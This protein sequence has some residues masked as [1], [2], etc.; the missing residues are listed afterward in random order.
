MS[1]IFVGID[2]GESG[3]M[4]AM[5]ADSSILFARPWKGEVEAIES[6][7]FAA[8]HGGVEA[9]IERVGGFI[10]GNPMPGSKM[11]RFGESYGWLRGLMSGLRI[12]Y[13]TVRPQDWQKGLGIKKCERGERKRALRDLA[14]QRFPDVKATLKT[15]DSILIAEWLR[16]ETVKS[17]APIET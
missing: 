16:R 5:F 12:P 6:I 8:E 1:E 3:G 2:P 7:Q 13:C 10:Q 9:A 14:A 17:A 15:A 11:F 4:T